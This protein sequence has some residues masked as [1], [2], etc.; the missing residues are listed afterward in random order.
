MTPS[1][2]QEYPIR[3]RDP[4]APLQAGCFL[5]ASHYKIVDAA[6]HAKDPSSGHTLSAQVEAVPAGV[7][8]RVDSAWPVTLVHHGLPLPLEAPQGADGPGETTL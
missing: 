6:L 1:I 8:V 5:Q 3:R 4:K 2:H 7:D